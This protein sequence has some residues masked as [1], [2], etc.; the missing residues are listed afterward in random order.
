MV[1]VGKGSSNEEAPR[2]KTPAGGRLDEPDGPETSSFSSEPKADAG[3]DAVSDA[4]AVPDLVSGADAVSSAG[5][6]S[7]A[8]AV[9]DLVSGTDSVSGAVHV[10][11]P[12]SGGTVGTGTSEGRLN[13]V[14]SSSSGRG[15]TA[16]V[17]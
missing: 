8:G 16:A 1:R 11:E 12:G 15:A 2:E 6:V 14:A 5:A 17:V 10:P 3:A 9:P 4:G 7:D 13:L